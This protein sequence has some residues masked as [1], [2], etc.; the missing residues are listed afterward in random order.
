MMG[1]TGMQIGLHRQGHIFSKHNFDHK[2]RSVYTYQWPHKPA[3]QANHAWPVQNL[4][5]GCCPQQRQPKL[6]RYL[7]LDQKDTGNPAVPAVIKRRPFRA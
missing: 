7:G 1:G 2:V 5:R 6:P 3:T 4:S